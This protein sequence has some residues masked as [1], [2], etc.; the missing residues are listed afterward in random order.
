LPSNTSGILASPMPY[1]PPPITVSCRIVHS[2]FDPP[3]VTNQAIYNSKDPMPEL[4]DRSPNFDNFDDVITA[5]QDQSNIWVNS[6]GKLPFVSPPGKRLPGKRP[7][8]LSVANATSSNLA[9]QGIRTSKLY[10]SSELPDEY[11]SGYR[12]TWL[13]T[14]GSSSVITW[15]ETS[16]VSI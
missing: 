10:F 1:S 5:P 8:H 3:P 7:L 2:S 12:L 13:S 9:V 6:D 4:L 14:S 15:R 16:G 11:K